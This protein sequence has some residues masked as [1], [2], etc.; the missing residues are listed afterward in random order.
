MCYIQKASLEMTRMYAGNK[1]EDG[2]VCDEVKSVFA[3]RAPAEEE[4]LKLYLSN[5]KEFVRRWRAL[6]RYCLRRQ[7]SYLLLAHHSSL[8][9]TYP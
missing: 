4:A 9:I 1:S 6:G 8:H 2:V 3:A 7:T 5:S